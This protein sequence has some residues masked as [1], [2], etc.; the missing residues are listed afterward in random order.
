[1]NESRVFFV[2]IKW[3][4]KYSIFSHP[5]NHW[6]SYFSRFSNAYFLLNLLNEQT[7]SATILVGFNLWEWSNVIILNE[8]NYW[9]TFF[10][11]SSRLLLLDSAGLKPAGS[12]PAVG[13]GAQFRAPNRGRWTSRRSRCSQA[14][15]LFTIPVQQIEKVRR[16]PCLKKIDWISRF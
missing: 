10:F 1:M 13:Q 9:T 12:A 11:R 3:P 2:H 16:C 8:K 15:L 5:P 7:W 14:Q 6:L 4:G